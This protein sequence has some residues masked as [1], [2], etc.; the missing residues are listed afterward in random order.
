MQLIHKI[1]RLLPFIFVASVLAQGYDDTFEMRN[2]I[3]VELQYADYGE[4]E[5][6]EPIVYRYGVNEYLQNY[7]YIVNFP[8]KR[9]LVKFTRIIGNTTAASI[10]YQFS[11]L[12]EGINQHLGEVKFTK[13]MGS[14]FIGLI[15][16]QFINDTRKFNAYQPGLGFQWQISPYTILQGDA[17]YYI[18]GKDAEPV[19]G[20]M[21]AVNARIKIRQV[22]TVSTALLLEYVFYNA[23]GENL[24]FKSHNA[25]IWLSQ[26]LPTQSAIHVNLR[27][28]NNS[29]GIHSFA[30]SVEFAQYLDWATV[31]RLKYR[32]YA[33]K[34]DN[35]SLGEKDVIV[36]D[37]LKSNSYSVQVNREMSSDLELYGLYRYY[38]S[39]LHVRMNT[40][41]LGMVVG[42]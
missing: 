10:K 23:D 33:N 9:G 21:K 38:Q 30:P 36:P 31:L 4:Y 27:Y 20:E 32:Y 18:R 6:P 29:M 16:G 35:V 2:K 22:V 11:E 26:F 24:Q 34:S 1:F 37:N 25:S 8:E 41:L 39:N 5:Y 14:A 13:N 3:K 40:Y 17:Q 42:F 19:G 15:S 28:Y 7:P 12:R